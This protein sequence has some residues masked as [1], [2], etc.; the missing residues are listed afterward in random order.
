MHST[1]PKGHSVKSVPATAPVN[2]LIPRGPLG[3]VAVHSAMFLF[4]P[5]DPADGI[6]TTADAKEATCTVILGETAASA[7]DAVS[8]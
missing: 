1:D 8:A 5:A 6:S 7:F 4:V 2:P 3:A